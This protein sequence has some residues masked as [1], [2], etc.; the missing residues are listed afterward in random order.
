MRFAENLK[1]LP[2]ISHIAT[3]RLLDA[4][5]NEIARIENKPGSAGSVAVYNYLAQIYGAITMEA[6]EKGL[7]LYAEHTEEARATPGKHPSIDRLIDIA[8]GAPVLKVKP[9]FAV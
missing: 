2:R 6:A 7:E 1:K 8:A 3:L 9:V 4:D 5:G